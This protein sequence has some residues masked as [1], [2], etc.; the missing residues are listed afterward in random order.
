MTRHR[1]EQVTSSGSDDLSVNI[2]AYRPRITV[3]LPFV[4]P[5]GDFQVTSVEGSDATTRTT[6]LR[7]RS[8]SP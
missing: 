1:L 8:T 5:D 2:S 7:P 6:Y 4:L 3:L